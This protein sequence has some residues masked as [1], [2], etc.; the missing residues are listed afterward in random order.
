MEFLTD[1]WTW[2]IEPFT[3]NVFMQ[4]ALLAGL[5][6]VVATSV[7]G[8]WVVL[9]GM[10]F[11]GDALAHGVLPGIAL[12]VVI[13]VS[14]TLGALVAAAVMVGGVHVVRRHSPLPE[15]ASIG[16]LFV[17]ML[18]LAV[19][20]V[21]AGAA[22]DAGDLHRVLFGSVTG[23]EADDLWRQAIAA[24]IAVGGAIAFHR[25]FLVLTFDETQAELLGLRPRL[26]HLALMGLVAMSVVA[27]FEA[28][29]SL[30]V[31]AFLVA[32]P[33][34][35]VLVARRIPLVMATAVGVGSVAVVL[36]A[37]IS[38]HHDTAAG[39]T[40]A[41]VAVVL[42]FAVMG[43]QGLRDAPQVAR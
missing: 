24:A 14:P 6:A 33:A 2:W 7:V 12:A 34:T 4:R 10:T 23:L 41:L 19:V 29:G 16:L 43:V 3:A 42:C 21:S 37:L 40:M 9:R 13:G 28:V 22:A 31:F 27:S 18:A 30:L 36:G 5:L 25:A 8:T 15:D 38:Y 26:A 20:I 1:P 17:G 11:L 35:A 39:A 32:P